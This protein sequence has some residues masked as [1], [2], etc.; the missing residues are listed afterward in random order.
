MNHHF[1]L[2]EQYQMN[3]EVLKVIIEE[4]DTLKH[5]KWAGGTLLDQ[6]LVT[7]WSNLGQPTPHYIPTY[8]LLSSKPACTEDEIGIYRRTFG[9]PIGSCPLEPKIGL[10]HTGGNHYCCLVILPQ[11]GENHV[12]GRLISNHCQVKNAKNWDTWG[13]PNIWKNVTLLHGWEMTAVT[14]H[15]INWHQNGNDCGPIGCQVID[16][17]WRCGFTLDKNRMWV[18]PTLPCVHAI[19]ISMAINSRDRVLWAISQDQSHNMHQP[20]SFDEW[21]GVD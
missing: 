10:M 7:R 14:V 9:L 12:L 11:E 21:D 17:I 18:M 16:F 2:T 13:G 4:I 5:G 3:P 8:H 19:R 1:L 15:E 20:S 6:W